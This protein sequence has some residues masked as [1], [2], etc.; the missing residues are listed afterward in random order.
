MTA[1]TLPPA[2]VIVV[3]PQPK[4]HAR[5]RAP[6]PDAPYDARHFFEYL[7]VLRER[8]TLAVARAEAGREELNRLKLL[9]RIFFPR[10]VARLRQLPTSA[11]LAFG[12]VLC[13]PIWLSYL[14]R[15][16]TLS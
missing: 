15:Y 5:P 4:K 16:V 12:V 7:E 6:A 11:W 8:E 13:S 1:A 2:A 10:I 9:W 3:R 14:Y